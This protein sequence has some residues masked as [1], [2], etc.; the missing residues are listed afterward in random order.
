[1]ARV[2]AKPS[3]SPKTSRVRKS[4]APAT[5][6]RSK[7]KKTVVKRDPAISPTIPDSDASSRDTQDEDDDEEEEDDNDKEESSEDSQNSREQRQAKS[8][9][10]KS[11]KTPR[12]A[13]V[14]S[15]SSSNRRASS[16]L[17]RNQPGD[18]VAALTLLKPRRRIKN[19]MAALREIR[20]FQ[21]S[22]DLLIRKLPFARL[23]REI[24]QDNFPETHH[25]QS[26]A[27][28]ALQEASEAYLVHFLEDVN[29]CA[30]HAKRV[31][32]MQKDIFLAKRL[33]GE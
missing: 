20:K 32:I 27:L 7:S 22:T 11:K 28:L 13:P 31:T 8:R 2:K 24:V 1:M 30:I 16:G 33:R 6:S 12:K 14:T 19:G 3:K 26:V 10:K 21:K 25:W 4:N 29:L 5:P 18:P 23:V 15:S 17:E 9:S